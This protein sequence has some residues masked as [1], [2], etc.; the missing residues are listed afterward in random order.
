MSEK[1]NKNVPELR[2]KG[3][4]DAWV[5]REFAKMVDRVSESS[6]AELPRV[7]FED[8]ISGMGRLNKDVTKPEDG[9]DVK[10]MDSLFWHREVP[11]SE[12]FSKPGFQLKTA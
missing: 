10:I 12:N 8:L 1:T 3:F 6:A 7:E 4:S 2:F 5:Q 11:H 9:A